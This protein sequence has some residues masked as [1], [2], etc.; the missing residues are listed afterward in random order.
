MFTPAPVS[1]VYVTD[2]GLEVAHIEIPKQEWKSIQSQ[3]KQWAC[4]IKPGEWGESFV[5]DAVG[6]GLI[7]EVGTAKTFGLSIDITPL[8]AG[9]GGGSDFIINGVTVEVKTATGRSN[10]NQL[11][12]RCLTAG[13]N[14]VPLRSEIYIAAREVFT[15]TGMIV[16]LMGWATR[17][18]LLKRDTVKG[19]SGKHKNKA[20]PYAELRPIRE[21]I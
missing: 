9:T 5:D 19:L 4:E 7:G 2:Q 14:P 20:I 12:V 17:E 8:S 10:Y 6:T 18:D 15:R 11:L 1:T 13:G 16:H 21:L 3:R